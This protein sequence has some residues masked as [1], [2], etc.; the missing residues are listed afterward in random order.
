MITDYYYFHRLSD[1]CRIVYKYI[2]DGLENHDE[3]IHIPSGMIE[4]KDLELILGAIIK[5]NPQFFYFYQKCIRFLKSEDTDL[6]ILDY[7]MDLHQAQ[8]FSLDIQKNANSIIN[9]SGALQVKTEYD[10]IKCIYDML[11][12]GLTYDFDSANEISSIDSDSFSKKLLDID[13]Y[14][15][16]ILGVFLRKKAVCEGIAKAFKLILNSLDIF[17]IVVDGTADID[18]LKSKKSF[19][20]TWNI[21]KINGELYHI[22][23]T[24]AVEESMDERINYDYFCLNDEQIRKDHRFDYD[25]PKCSSNKYNYFSRNGLTFKKKSDLKRFLD[26]QIYSAALDIYCR[27]DYDCDFS[28]EVFQIYEYAIEKLSG[29][30][31][32]GS[33][34]ISYREKQRI[35]RMFTHFF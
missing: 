8:N 1:N 2:F 28:G 12:T 30:G 14:S 18:N 9:K 27:I 20:H 13:I 31:W 25:T 33:I 32:N 24:W 22:D 35:F 10:K 15:Y 23:L 29:C 3:I 11:A 6:I 4:E 16:T 34:S 26:R 19:N 21:V 7:N 17:C 5:D